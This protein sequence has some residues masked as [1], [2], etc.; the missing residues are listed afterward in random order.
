M[1]VDVLLT[2]PT[3]DSIERT[4]NGG[5]FAWEKLADLPQSKLP[6]TRQQHG[7]HERHAQKCLWA[8]FMS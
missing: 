1:V 6:N 5:Y 2:R 7:L 4:L 8:K 3:I